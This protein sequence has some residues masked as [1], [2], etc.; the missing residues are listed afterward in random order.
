MES[1][2]IIVLALSGLLLT[3]AGLN[4]LI[5]PMSSLCLTMYSKNPDVKLEYKSDVFNEMRSA[6][7]QLLVSG[8]IILAGIFITQLRL[9]A[10]VLAASIFLG[11]A[12]GRLVA[13]KKDG[14]VCKEIMSGLYSEIILGVL[15]AISLVFTFLV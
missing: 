5:K 9:T 8:L 11:Y 13:I 14:K 7:S 15:N 1:F 4:R 10:L 3:Y 12:F 6:G 2:N